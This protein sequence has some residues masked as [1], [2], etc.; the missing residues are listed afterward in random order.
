MK[1]VFVS[2]YINHH[3]IP[4]CNAMCRELDGDI[5]ENGSFVFIQTQPM[6]EERVKMG[7]QEEAALPFLKLYYKE[8]K[9]CR[10]LILES[11]LVLFGGCEEEAYI[12]ERLLAGKPVVRL[13]ERLYKS[14]QW[15]AVSPRGL[16]KKFHDHTRYRNKPVYLL[17][18]GAY[19][20]SDFHIVRAY[21]KKMYRWGYFPPTKQY[22]IEDLMQKKGY[23]KE[24]IPYLLW[25]GR[26]IEW[27]HP[28]MP[29]KA[30]KWLKDRGI[31]F[32]MDII[33]GGELEP[34]IRR[35]IA[36]EG[37]EEYVSLIGFLMPKEV[38]KYME[39]ANIY[40]MTSDR[41]EGWGAVVNEAMNSGCAVVAGHMAGCV[42]YLIKH[43]KNGLIFQDKKEKQFFQFIEELVCNHEKCMKLGKNAYATITK[44]WNAEN[45]AACFMELLEELN[46]IKKDKKDK[47]EKNIESINQQKKRKRTKTGPCSFAP[48][49]SERK[50][51]DILTK[52]RK[53]K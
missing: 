42:P 53:Y 25:A 8:E 29:V 50:M 47:K 1:I 31:K 12:E 45:A 30:A 15:K 5:I 21:P 20:P 28:Q 7:W 43:R 49:I 46:I 32:H 23:G 48:V 33:G 14:G 34:Q 11:D 27:K 18:Y 13:S 36:E 35:M 41:E 3:Q 6:E 2:N 10:R 24:K 22:Q 39:Q 44:E 52:N 40:L 26:F 9:T 51:Y 16:R 4:F 38:R 19:V 37:L 17:C